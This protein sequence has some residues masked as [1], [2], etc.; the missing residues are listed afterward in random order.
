MDTKEEGGI[1][2][3]AVGSVALGMSLPLSESPPRLFIC[4]M[5]QQSPPY[6][7]FWVLWSPLSD[8]VILSWLWI[9]G[10]LGTESFILL[11]FSASQPHPRA[12]LCG[13]RRSVPSSP[14][15]ARS[16]QPLIPLLPPRLS[17]LPRCPSGRHGSHPGRL[18]SC[19]ARAPAPH[20][21]AAAGT[22]PAGLLTHPT[23]PGCSAGEWP[24]DRWLSGWTP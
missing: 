8:T 4:K 14:L 21:A 13:L 5:E 20:S 9:G 23:G 24:A 15:Q 12:V 7:L 1:L 19:A 6:L 2:S 18:L 11:S 3:L 22:P 17:P 16:L 10:D